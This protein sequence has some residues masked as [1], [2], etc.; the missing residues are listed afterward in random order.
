MIIADNAS[1]I[2]AAFDTVDL[3]EFS[4]LEESEPEISDA[5]DSG[6]EYEDMA[7][8]DVLQHNENDQLLKYIQDLQL[9]RIP[10]MA[11]LLQLA[12]QDAV[13]NS[14]VA[15]KMKKRVTHLTIFF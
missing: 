1:N 12:I 2:L 14:P 10:C 4:F 5:D 7:Y 15:E 6:S 11:H 8:L 13:K 3:D 9:T